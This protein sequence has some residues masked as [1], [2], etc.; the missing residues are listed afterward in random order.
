MKT[1]SNGNGIKWFLIAV[2]IVAGMIVTV[3]DTRLQSWRVAGE[4]TVIEKQTIYRP[5]RPAD[6][7]ITVDLKTGLESIDVSEDDFDRWNIGDRC[8]V[9]HRVAALGVMD[10]RIT[11]T[12]ENRR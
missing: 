7:I 3:T 8:V 10:A 2:A 9:E 4:A 1:T 5:N 12:K 6:R 11:P